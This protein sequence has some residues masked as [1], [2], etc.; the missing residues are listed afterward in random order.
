MQLAK[1]YPTC[2]RS[3]RWYKKI[4]FFLLDMAIVNAFCVYKELGNRCTQLQFK[5]KLIDELLVSGTRPGP[6]RTPRPT[7]PAPAGRLTHP[8]DLT[9][10]G[11]YRRCHLC[12]KDSRRRKMTRSRCI[13]CK[14]A[15]CTFGCFE[16]YH[17]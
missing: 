10:G 2:R 13:Q 14:V 9:D 17:S 6:S 16:R 15:L 7:Q 8:V 5:E 3:P 4:F 1:S 12:W 11:K